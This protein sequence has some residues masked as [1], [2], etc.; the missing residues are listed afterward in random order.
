M[1]PSP[2]VE[3]R[4]RYEA[5]EEVQERQQ[6]KDALEKALHRAAPSGTLSPGVPSNK[7]PDG[8]SE[9]T[10]SKNH[11]HAEGEEAPSTATGRSDA[12][13]PEPSPAPIGWKERISNFC[14]SQKH[15]TDQPFAPL[16][17]DAFW[18]HGASG[19]DW[20][21]PSGGTAPGLTTAPVAPAPVSPA[22]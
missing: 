1:R 10:P 15:D 12:V 14:G 11:S 4:L 17:E 6:E 3:R 13:S 21:K 2:A 19:G 5:A 18:R 22:A 16:P 20:R 7:G 9:E 8:S